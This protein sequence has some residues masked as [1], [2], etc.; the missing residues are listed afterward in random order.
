MAIKKVSTLPTLTD[1]KTALSGNDIA[2]FSLSGNPLD[3]GYSD[4]G[5]ASVGVPFSKLLTDIFNQSVND[6][7]PQYVNTNVLSGSMPTSYTDLVL[8]GS[9]G[10]NRCMVH[11][12][13]KPD[14]DSSIV[15]RPNGETLSA[16]GGVSTALS[17]TS[18]KIA[19]IKVYTDTAGR[20][21]WKADVSGSGGTTV[22]LIT[23]QI[24]Q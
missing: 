18:D 24:L 1:Y 15:F 14:T 6:Y 4:D 5:F 20:V 22:D 16:S 9:T 23:Y 3:S 19:Y 17:A 2:L 11:L 7:L 21:E 13:V 12:K 10:A 8:S